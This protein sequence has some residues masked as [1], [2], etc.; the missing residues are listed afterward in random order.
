MVVSCDMVEC[1]KCSKLNCRACIDDWTKKQP[2]CPNCRSE[3][4]A[5]EQPNLYVANLL[6]DFQF[7]CTK[8]KETFAYRNQLRHE[9]ECSSRKL[10][11]PMC[12]EGNI[13]ASEI[14]SHLAEQCP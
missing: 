3:Y 13:S 2:D 9:N 1:G 7:K 4:K 12:T 14:V 11:C 10:T 8:C 5:K 6:K